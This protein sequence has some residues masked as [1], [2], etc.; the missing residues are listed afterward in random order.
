M[1]NTV[2]A[3]AAL[4]LSAAVLSAQGQSLSLAYA[5]DGQA[6]ALASYDAVPPR[7]LGPLAWSYGPVA[8]IALSDSRPVA[9]LGVW[10]VY[11]RPKEPFFGRIGLN[12][13]TSERKPV[14][15]VQVGLGLRL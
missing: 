2:R 13:L 5:T 3:F 8:G 6:Y 11:E 9:G 1:R 12:V 15:V 10:A 14:A 7:P 4:A